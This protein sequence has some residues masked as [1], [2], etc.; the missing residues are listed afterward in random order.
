M[1]IDKYQEKLLLSGRYPTMAKALELMTG[2][3]MV[4]TG[5]VRMKDDWGAGMSTLVFGDYAHTGGAHLFTVDI[6]PQ[7][8]ELS[9]EITGEFKDAI[10]YVVSDSIAFLESFNQRIDFL[11]LDSMD[12]PEY[13]EEYSPR[14]VASQEHQLKELMTAWDK[15]R[16]GSVILLDDN[17]FANG[18][19]TKRTK[20]ELEILGA[21]PIMEG[22]QSLWI[23]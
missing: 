7:N 11:Y 8:I 1:W 3:I 5:T 2:R 12:C 17:D 13:D 20:K 9:Q 18:G 19:K 6:D 22:K 14:L 23:K 4:E 10:T 21:T 16:A 15:L